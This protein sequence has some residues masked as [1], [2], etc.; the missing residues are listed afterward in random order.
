MSSTSVLFR[1]AVQRLM[2]SSIF[3]LIVNSLDYDVSGFSLGE[4]RITLCKSTPH[5]FRTDHG[6]LCSVPEISLRR[7]R[8]LELAQDNL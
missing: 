4:Y 2:S 3:V 7:N 5:R 1:L 8:S 6:D